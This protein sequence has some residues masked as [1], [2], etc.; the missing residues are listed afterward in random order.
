MHLFS[1][2]LLHV[3]SEERLEPS[4]SSV[5][6]IVLQPLIC[7]ILRGEGKREGSC[8]WLKLF[9]YIQ[10]MTIHYSRDRD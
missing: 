10:I 1:D 9:Q 3:I 4:S 6:E 5:P 7:Q 8:L 2:S